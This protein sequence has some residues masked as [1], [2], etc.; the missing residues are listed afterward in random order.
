MT[1]KNKKSPQILP[2]LKK[3]HYV[4]NFCKNNRNKTVKRWHRSSNAGPK[5]IGGE[6]EWIVSVP[7]RGARW[8]TPPTVCLIGSAILRSMFQVAAKA[9]LSHEDMANLEENAASLRVFLRGI[10][11]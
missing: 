1:K 7:V 9:P 3:K 11:V 10:E 8:E 6:H 5:K 4:A 2:A